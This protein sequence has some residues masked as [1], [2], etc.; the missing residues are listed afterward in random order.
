MIIKQ[1]RVF[2]AIQ[3]LAFAVNNLFQQKHSKVLK[4]TKRLK[5]TINLI[6]LIHVIFM[7]TRVFVFEYYCKS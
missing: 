1:K 4:P 7:I 6:F 5:S 3:N 2:Q